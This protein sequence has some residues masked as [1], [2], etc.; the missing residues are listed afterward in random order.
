M[1]R[2]IARRVRERIRE[3]HPQTSD[4][5]RHGAAKKALKGQAESAMNDEDRGIDDIDE[6][7]DLGP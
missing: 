1:V 4:A 5:P 6:P 3:P 2:G 7:R